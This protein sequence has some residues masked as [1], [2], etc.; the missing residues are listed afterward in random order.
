VGESGGQPHAPAVSTPEKD[1]VS[2]VQ[3][4]EWTQ[5]LVRRGGKPRPHRDYFLNDTFIGPHVIKYN[6]KICL[7]LSV[8]FDDVSVFFPTSP[9]VV[10]CLAIRSRTVHTVVSRYTD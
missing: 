6:V 3:D 10:L 4:T 8:L 1:P 9:Q 5:G 7:M 2:N